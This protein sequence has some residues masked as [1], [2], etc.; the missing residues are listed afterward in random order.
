MRRNIPGRQT[1]DKSGDLPPG[2][3][4]GTHGPVSVYHDVRGLEVT[5][6]S[7]RAVRHFDDV[8]DAYLHFARDT[9]A[10]LKQTLAADADFTLAHC[11]KGYFFQLFCIGA[12]EAKAR[13]SLDTA[14]ASAAT[15]GV[16]PR[17]QLHL[18]ALACWIAGDLTGAA[19]CWETI[20]MAHPH[21]VLAFKLETYTRF[22]LGD[23]IRIRDTAA[24]VMNAWD[25]SLPGYH[26]I[27]SVHAFGLEECGDY[28]AAER[29]GRRSVE[30]DAEDLWGVHAV[31]HVME[32]QDR[33]K[34]GIAWLEE[35]A[36]N[37]SR[38]NNFVYHLWWHLALFYMELEDYERVLSLYDEKVRADTE[39][40]EYLDICNATSLLWRL[41]ERGIDVGDRWRELAEKAA[42]RSNDHLLVFPDAHFV[43]ALAGSGD[44]D[45]LE[46][47]L[48]SMR[49]HAGRAGVTESEISAA[50]GLPVCE[51]VA[52][53]YAKRYG[54]V[55]DLLLPVRYAVQRIGGSHAQRDM[56]WQMLIV[57]CLRSGRIHEARALLA[58]R[59]VL[60]P[61]NPWTWRRYAEA[62]EAAGETAPA[63]EARVRA[64]S[65]LA[66]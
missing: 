53:W 46:R 59:T 66:A 5:S 42:Q 52:A 8:I 47:M 31:A 43:L 58:E 63:A 6:A 22:Y 65:L 20:L 54:R 26:A 33:R 41:E 15:R 56:F 34:D 38:G 9:G 17:E 12:L 32:M 1:P 37:W 45:V 29:E 48:A 19:A 24:R 30:L 16:T 13:V 3:I 4:P 36:P 55:V 51:A 28:P 7:A 10:H 64:E 35:S 57:A 40:T 2:A 27:L 61:G 18:D 14:R 62:L 39:S 21:D 60:R 23:S 11:A 25:A 49:A 44:T 50:V